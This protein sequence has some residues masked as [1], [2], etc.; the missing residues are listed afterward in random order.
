MSSTGMAFSVV[1]RPIQ[2]NNVTRSAISKFGPSIG[3]NNILFWSHHCPN[4]AT[5]LK[6]QFQVCSQK[7]FHNFSI[8]RAKRISSES[9]RHYSS[10]MASS[11]INFKDYDAFGFDLDHTIAKYDLV[12]LFNVSY[13]IIYS[14]E[15][16]IRRRSVTIQ[17]HYL[18][19]YI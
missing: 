18:S 12:M 16:M 4:T 13:Q 10:T 19:L 8:L 15:L 14:F 2:R 6:R 9:S 3:S 7:S 11:I 1:I 17:Y 5:L